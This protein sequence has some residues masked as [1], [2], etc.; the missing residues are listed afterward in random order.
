MSVSVSVS[1]SVSV[2]VCT[3][4]HGDHE[5]SGGIDRRK[6]TALYYMNP[7]WAQDQVNLFFKFFLKN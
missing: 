6:L 7:N 1:E 2:S 5:L 4:T 3:H